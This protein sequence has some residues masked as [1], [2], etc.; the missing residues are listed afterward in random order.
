MYK[1]I[2]KTKDISREEWLRLR[3]NGLGG[4]DAGAVCGLNP[5]VSPMEVYMSKTC[6]DA[7]EEIPDNE[8]MREGRD[9]EDYVAKRFME[10][11]GL[12]VRRANMMYA[13][14]ERPFMIANVDRLISG[15]TDGIIGLECKTASPYSA[16]KWQDGKIPA[17]YIMQCYHYMA[18]LDAKSWYIAVMIYG[19]EFKYIEL[20]RDEEIL[21]NLIRIEE[22]FWNHNVMKRIMPEPDGSDAADS[23]INKHFAETKEGLSVPLIGFSEKLQRRAEISDLINQLDTEKKKI[24]QEIKTYMSDAEYAE[25]EDFLVSWKN[26][27]SNRIDTKRFKEEMP[28]LYKRFLNP[29]RSR[30]FLVK[31]V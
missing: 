23:F 6:D 18:V 5:Y 29:V 28:E 22:H 11:S 21:Q 8:A 9:F 27:I 14:K 30:K 3:K 26:S 10:A 1:I 17:H 16:E 15:R 24:E 20:K 2:A 12:K 31:A 7:V 25:N 19:K 4:S 13:N